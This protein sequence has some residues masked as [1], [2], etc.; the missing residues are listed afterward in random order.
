MTA[1]FGIRQGLTRRNFL[2]LTGLAA[3]GVL[4][5]ACGGGNDAPA[6]APTTG[7]APPVAATQAL[8]TARAT[9]PP[10]PQQRA[11]QPT[12]VTGQTPVAAPARFKE[13][14]QL[15]DLVKQGKL[16]PVED[17]LPKNPVV[18]TPVESVGR[19]GGNWRGGLLGATNSS[20]LLRTIGYEHL[21]RWDPEW[22]SVIPNV[23]ESFT[24][25]PDAREFTFTLREG[26]KW[27]DGAPFT[28]DD[29]VFYVEDYHKVK[30]LTPSRGGNPPE[31]E[32]VDR[33]TVRIT[34]AQP[35]GLFLQNLATPGGAVW[36]R[37]PKHYLQQFHQRY[38][39][40]NLDQ[41]V[42]E[43][44]AEDW[45]KLFQT[46]GG[47]I[48]G[49]PYDARWNNQDLPTLNGWLLTQTYGGGT[50]VTAERNPYYFKVDTAGNQLPYIDRVTYDVA[51][52]VQTL[53]LKALNGEI[54]MQTHH[55]GTRT[56]KAVFADN[57]QKG[58]Y[59]FFDTVPAGMN[60]VAIMLNLTHKDPTKRQIFQNKDFRIGL[61]HAIDRQ[62]II[63]VVFVSQG[64]PWQVGP[65]KESPLYNER[66]AKQYTEYDPAKANATLDR[67]FP[68]KDAQGFRLG[69]DGKRISF[70]IECSTVYPDHVTVLTL[71]KGMWQK[72]GVEMQ[73]KDEAPA[74]FDTRR[75]AN[76]HDAV[77]WEAGD[78]GLDVILSP[79]YFF[80][81]SG[82][83]DYAQAWATAYYNPSG[84]G[85]R[86]APED[87]PPAAKQQM[88]LY[89]QILATTDQGRQDALMRQLLEIAAEQFY[90]IGVTLITNGYGIVRNNVKNVPR[91]MPEA[92]VYPHPAPTNP[93]QYFFAS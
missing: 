18:L 63:D 15:A 66:L 71:I 51:Q 2:Y 31:V 92:F 4:A 68:Q 77:T 33:Y 58:G 65:R 46:K 7:G 42:R 20:L 34:F 79:A 49:T 73:F 89:R 17:R 21:V 72:V 35:N 6:A 25:S 32:K 38:N 16:P 1:L 43:H 80:P 5:T 9:A 14:P 27:S 90:V 86:T 52:D 69:P 13:A 74:L 82:R 44:G 55:I 57:Q 70:Q 12:I 59:R 83:S 78:G 47:A 36:T 48:A 88:D 76:E 3:T 45:V 62:E 23:A 53:V 26:L 39:T 85:A 93:A 22:K 64:E 67:A 10:T 84:A 75:Q 11:I 60:D 40:T 50:R 28:A 81:F 41:L 30:E 8:A 56:N 87:P 37:Y 19:Y 91:I 29:I 54:D 61:S 24:A